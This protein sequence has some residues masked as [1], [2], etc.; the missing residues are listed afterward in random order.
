MNKTVE[1]PRYGEQFES[2]QN[3][4]YYTVP[5]ERLNG[6]HYSKLAAPPQHDLYIMKR[7]A[8]PPFAAAFTA[9]LT[10]VCAPGLSDPAEF[11]PGAVD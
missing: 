6:I 8:R 4:D 1:S 9:S 11:H 10:G 5:K 2:L 7:F 3:S